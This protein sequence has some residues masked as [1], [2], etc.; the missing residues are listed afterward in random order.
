MAKPT[1]HVGRINNTDARVVIVFP[2][3]PDNPGLSLVVNTDTLHPRL[4][5][6]LMAVV[7]N[8]GQTNPVLA[9]VLQRRIFTDTGIDLL[10]TLHY[11]KALQPVP[12]DNITLYPYP[13]NPIPLAM[14][15]NQSMHQ[16]MDHNPVS[17][18][19]PMQRSP[20][21][22]RLAEA[23]QPQ[24]QATAAVAQDMQQKYNQYLANQRA[25]VTEEQVAVAQNM[26]IEA[27]ELLRTAQIK[28]E[29]AFRMAP[30]LRP[31]EQKV[32]IPSPTL[33]A[34]ERQ[35]AEFAAALQAGKAAQDVPVAV[36]ADPVAQ[37]T[38]PNRRGG[39]AKGEAA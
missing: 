18:T 22:D 13:N 1:F 35:N 17:Q 21:H 4:H 20:Y 12:I 30:S 32:N 31:A 3:N 26:L 25:G 19:P 27:E 24:P 8:E 14:V 37:A 5:D 28:R 39:K 9:H 11:A 29:Q 10:T 33:A 15:L 38:K 34:E 36:V 23:A 16:T 7:E 6:A 2:Q